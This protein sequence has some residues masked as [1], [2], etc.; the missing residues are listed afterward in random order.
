MLSALS[1]VSSRSDNTWG[2]KALR[3]GRQARSGGAGL[4]AVSPSCSTRRPCRCP[5]LVLSLSLPRQEVLDC[6]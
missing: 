3:A 2:G 6:G 1:P 5:G 4:R